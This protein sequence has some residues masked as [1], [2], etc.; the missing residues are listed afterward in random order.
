MWPFVKLPRPLVITIRKTSCYSQCPPATA[1]TAT[2][3]QIDPSYSLH[4]A[5]VYPTY[6]IKQTETIINKQKIELT[7]AEKFEDKRITLKHIQNE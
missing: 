6:L 2:T 4:G 3:T 5:N 7:V 1:S